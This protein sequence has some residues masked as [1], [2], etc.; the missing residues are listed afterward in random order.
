MLQRWAAFFCWI[1]NQFPSSFTNTYQES[2]HSCGVNMNS[3]NRFNS[4]S[5]RSQ[6]LQN[7]WP[8]NNNFSALHHPIKKI[9]PKFKSCP[10]ICSKYSLQ[11]VALG[12]FMHSN[13]VSSARDK[14]RTQ[15]TS[16]LIPPP[17]PPPPYHHC[18][19]NKTGALEKEVSY[20]LTAVISSCDIFF[21]FLSSY[22]FC[23]LF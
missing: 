10:K 15:T 11:Q 12:W 20:N 23:K 14:P 13:C 16:L 22:N 21:L 9:R 17:S 5:C 4:C 2:F 6:V 1:C 19:F 3:Q 7:C 18:F 8:V